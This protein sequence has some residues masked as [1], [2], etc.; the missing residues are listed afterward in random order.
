MPQDSYSRIKIKQEGNVL[1]IILARAEKH[2]AFDERMIAEITR[3]FSDATGNEKIRVIV[4]EAEGK[5]FC[6]GADL[7]WMRR[8]GTLTYEENREDAARLAEMV[9][10]IFATPKPV[11]CCVQ[12]GV[13]G[14]GLGIVAACDIVVASE[15]AT[16]ALREVKVGIAPATIS[17]LLLR[18]MGES[19][20]RRIMLTGEKFSSVEAKEFGLVHRIAPHHL[21]DGIINNF[22]SEILQNGPQA[23]ASCK[24]LLKNVGLMSLEEAKEY[25]ARVIADLRL[26]SEGQEG[27]RAFLEKRKP[28]WTE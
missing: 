15:D 5:N 8:A 26:S 27:L 10:T 24:E 7:E 16:F 1:R 23:L 21:M 17:P 9:M 12:G 3:A 18:K 13:F 6:A 2:N 11:I 14:G 19:A 22:I 25:T 20:C 4:L 28:R